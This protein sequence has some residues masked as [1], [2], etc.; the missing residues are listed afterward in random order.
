MRTTVT[1][2][3]ELLEAAKRRARAHGVT[4][5]RVIEA[6][7]RRHLATQH[8]DTADP[9]IPIFTEGT[10]PRPGL[11]LTSNAALREELDAGLELDQRR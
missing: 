5:G 6:A 8:D 1:I 4:L 11:D 9:P 2:N 3:D 10:G 7:L